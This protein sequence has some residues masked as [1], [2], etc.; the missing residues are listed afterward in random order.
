MIKPIKIEREQ[1]DSKEVTKELKLDDVSRIVWNQCVG[2]R[3]DEKALIVVDKEHMDIAKSLL[4]V[5]NELCDCKIALIERRGIDTNEPSEAI[6]T[7]M[8]GSDVIIAPTTFSLTHTEAVLKAVENGAR[9]IT[10]PGITKE[11]YL[12][13]IP[14]DYKQMCRINTELMNKLNGREV[15]ITTK[16]G[17]DLYLRIDGRSFVNNCGTFTASPRKITNLPGGEIFI[18]PLE[19][20][21]EGK[22]II[23]T[24]SAPDSETKFGVIGRV[25][26]P[27]RI[28]VEGGEMVDCENDV[29]WKAVTSADHGTNLAELGIG[30]NEKAKIIGKILEDEKVMGTSHVAFGTNKS[31]GGVVQTSVHFDCVFMKPTVEV[32]GEIVIIEG[33]F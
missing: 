8:M 2:A 24:S 15:K 7:S 3:I 30:T 19:D 23:D 33:K 6:A 18:A 5:G 27:F 12:R 9:I 4:D 21:S 25:K 31:F 29:L 10:M 20:K 11:T 22:I 1:E 14:V 13:A 32:D 28:T 17:T 16:Q 26:R